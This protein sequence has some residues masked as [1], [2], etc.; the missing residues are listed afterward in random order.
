MTSSEVFKLPSQ[1]QIGPYNFK[2]EYVEKPGAYMK[3]E[4]KDQELAGCVS[5]ET[6]TIY[7]S[8]NQMPVVMADTLLHE[9]NHVVWAVAGG[10]AYEDAD[11]ERIIS[12]MTTTQLDTFLRNPKLMKFILGQ[13]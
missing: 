9:V 5:F 12:M 6:L 10:W 3:G 8:M 4:Q 13:S 1:V 11:E 7:I 2:I